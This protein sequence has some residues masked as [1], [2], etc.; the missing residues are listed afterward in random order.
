MNAIFSIILKK[1][2]QVIN[3]L[4]YG[5]LL[6]LVLR[7]F[8][9][10]SFRIPSYSMQPTVLAGDFVLISKQTPGSRFITNF[11][12]MGRCEKP[13]IIRLKG[14]WPIRRNDVLAFNF[15][16]TN[17]ERLQFNLNVYYLKR[18]VAVPGDTFY[19]Q[20]GIYKVKNCIDTLGC[21]LNQ[22]QLSQQTQA[23]Y[24]ERW[25]CFPGKTQHYDWNIKNF[26]PLYVPKAGDNLNI[27][28]INYLLY[29]KLIEYEANKSVSVYNGTVFFGD[30]AITS[31]TFK[32]NYFFVVGD[33]V[34]DSKD[35]RYWGLLP[36]D[37]IVGKAVFVWK[38]VDIQT[39]TTRWNRIFKKL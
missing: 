11:F 30:S 34:F 16:Y 37:H 2:W 6:A 1:T 24:G 19:I 14:L 33:Y 10:A 35:S 17:W 15:P 18:C 8:F 21:F 38:S 36:E 20:D 12:S 22:K 26:G 29:Q 28:T 23:D 7:V 31:Y 25:Q 32:S 5:F 3:V 39:K 9:I 13:K 4:F 27:D